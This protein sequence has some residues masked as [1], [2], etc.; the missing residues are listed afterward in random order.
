MH[1]SVLMRT[2]AARSQGKT[3]SQA[4]AEAL[5]AE[6]VL[7]SMRSQQLAKT[8]PHAQMRQHAQMLKLHLKLH[9]A[10]E[11]L[12]PRHILESHRRM[13]C[14]VRLSV[15]RSRSVCQ[16]IYLCTKD[17]CTTNC[18]LARKPAMKLTLDP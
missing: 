18:S 4:E 12:Q 2:E 7:A 17:G 8:Q 11:P 5:S 1:V 15:C 9:M 13:V 16:S 14:E 6:A 10:A 3:N